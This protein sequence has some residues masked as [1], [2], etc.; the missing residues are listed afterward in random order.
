MAHIALINKIDTIVPDHVRAQLSSESLV[1]W[2]AIQIHN[3]G[4][5]Q[6]Q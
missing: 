5:R 3:G 6:V 4:L 2:K 1:L